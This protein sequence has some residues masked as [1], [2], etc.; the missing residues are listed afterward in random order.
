MGIRSGRVNT[1]VLHAAWRGACRSPT[2]AFGAVRRRGLGQE[3][4]SRD[5]FRRFTPLGTALLRCAD[6]NGSR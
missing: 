5:G 6:P 4:G 2:P 3:G 1:A